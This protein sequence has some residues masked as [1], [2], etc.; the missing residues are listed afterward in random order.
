M[1]MGIWYMNQLHKNIS[2]GIYIYNDKMHSMEHFAATAIYMT[3]S[4]T[5]YANSF[6][7]MES[8]SLFIENFF[9]NLSL[10]FILFPHLISE[11]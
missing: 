2:E 8:P 7:N 1:T 5:M 9:F 11:K 10:I 6:N 3:L 4:I